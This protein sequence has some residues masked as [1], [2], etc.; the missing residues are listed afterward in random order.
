M[1][2]IVPIIMAVGAILFFVGLA[3]LI[4]RGFKKSTTVR[5]FRKEYGFGR[6][7]TSTIVSGVALIMASIYIQKLFPV[8]SVQADTSQVAT[9]SS[10]LKYELSSILH[11]DEGNTR[12]IRAINR[13]QKEYQEAL[14][15][16]DK[17]TTE[18]LILEMAFLIRTE[19]E[20]QNYPSHQIGSEVERI[21]NFLKR[22][23]D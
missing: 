11:G 9:I 12:M 10:N 8:E 7:V 23:P 20:N 6:F 19:L 18:L 1:N 22:K 16:G 17:N 5:F 15:N 13:F 14:V 4:R 3:V 2:P 21:M